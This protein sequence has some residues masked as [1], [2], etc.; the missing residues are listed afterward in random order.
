M[1]FTDQIPIR[2]PLVRSAIHKLNAFSFSAASHRDGIE[3]VKLYA[4]PPM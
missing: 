3:R 4:V 1:C 2:M